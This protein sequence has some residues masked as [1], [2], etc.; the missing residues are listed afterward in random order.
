MLDENKDNNVGELDGETHEFTFEEGQLIKDYANDMANNLNELKL[1][2]ED[3][4]NYIKT[5]IRERYNKNSINVKVNI[6]IGKQLTNI[7]CIVK[8]LNMLW[9]TVVREEIG[10][11]DRTAIYCMNLAESNIDEK[12]YFLGSDILDKF[13]T[14]TKAYDVIDVNELINNMLAS[15]ELDLLENDPNEFKR[16]IRNRCEF[17]KAKR[18]LENINDID[19]TLLKQVTDSEFRFTEKTFED[20]K[21]KLLLGINE[22]HQHLKDIIATGSSATTTPKSNGEINKKAEDFE[23][24]LGKI[25]VMA[26]EIVLGQIKHDPVP[27][28]VLDEAINR[29]VSV[30]EFWNNKK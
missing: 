7:K 12:Y 30:K 5:S 1:R 16:I 2:I 20:I 13:I 4:Y 25:I 18:K 26:K 29:I 10:I 8:S 22:V 3:L 21:A 9:L 27:D 17:L 19:E 6:E 14:E 15:K 23:S 28:H 11:K 24:L